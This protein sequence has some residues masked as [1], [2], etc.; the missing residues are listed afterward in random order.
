LEAKTRLVSQVCNVL[1]PSQGEVIDG[2]NLVPSLKQRVGQVTTD[3][4]GAT[5]DKHTHPQI[6]LRL[7]GPPRAHVRDS[8]PRTRECKRPTGK[9]SWDRPKGAR[10]ISTRYGAYRRGVSGP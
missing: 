7:V 8:R 1:F 2:D 3:E 5:G 4:A 6:S 10:R 9:C